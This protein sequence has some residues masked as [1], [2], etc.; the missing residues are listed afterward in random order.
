MTSCSLSIT[1]A[2]S[3]PS[4]RWWWLPKPRLGS[5]SVRWCSTMSSTIRRCLLGP[6]PPSTF[7]IED[8]RDRSR[9]LAE[10]AGDRLDDIECSALVQSTH[11]GVEAD[12][13]LDVMAQRFGVT[14]ELID[15]TPFLVVG[16]VEQVVDKLERLR[17]D[18]GISHFV[19]REPEGFAPVL[20]A[21]AGR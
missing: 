10:E 3:I 19:V 8:V 11:V 18:V 9:W 4:Y 20:D 1:S 16:S 14:R 6:L 17:S 7:A 13:E 21:L 2:R 5:A 12:D 15:E